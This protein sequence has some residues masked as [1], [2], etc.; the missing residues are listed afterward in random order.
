MPHAALQSRFEAM[1]SEHRGIV[2]KVAF[3]YARDAA[4]REDL[5]QEIAAQLW[6][7]FPRLDPARRVS[8]WM[9]RVALNVAISSLRKARVRSRHQPVPGEPDVTAVPAPASP[10][11]TAADAADDRLDVLRTCIDQLE[12]LSRALLV[13]YLDD[14][15]SREIAEILGISETNVT[16]RIGR[17]KSQLRASVQ[18]EQD[19]TA[20]AATNPAS[21]GGPHG[22]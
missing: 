6:Q 11:S 5:A 21:T 9:Y 22:T 3:A 17:L 10:L 4:D 14:R 7:S 8:T 20:A 2:L 13:L 12:P 15:S 19:A 1:L 18:R 16:T